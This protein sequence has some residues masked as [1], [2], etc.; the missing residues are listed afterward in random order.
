MKEETIPTMDMDDVI[1][2]RYPFYNPD[3][4]MKDVELCSEQVKKLMERYSQITS[5]PLLK[6]IE[7][8]EKDRDD[9]KEGYNDL[10]KIRNRLVAERNLYRDK[11]EVQVEEISQLQKRISELEGENNNLRIQLDW[12]SGENKASK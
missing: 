7:E 5:A 8:I 1:K 9:Y 12:D 11:F 4:A 3:I 10:S 6:R 2:E